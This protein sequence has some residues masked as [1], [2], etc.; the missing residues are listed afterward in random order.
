M[1]EEEELIVKTFCRTIFVLCTSNSLLFTGL[2][3]FCIE[4]PC[5]EIEIMSSG[6]FHVQQKAAL[7]WPD[8]A[9]WLT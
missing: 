6:V 5:E 3:L 7:F 1:L 8:T 2:A 4:Q 9:Q